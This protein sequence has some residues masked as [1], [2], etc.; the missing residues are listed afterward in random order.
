MLV[1]QP[2]GEVVDRL[3]ILALKCDRI[4]DPVRRAQAQTWHDALLARWAAADLPPLADLPELEPLRA[5]N[6]ELWDIE[7]ALRQC[8]RT[9][10]F[11][12]STASRPPEFT[13]RF[14][15]LA[16]RV[17]LANDERASLKAAIDRRLG[18]PLT[19]P[20][21]HAAATATAGIKPPEPS[22]S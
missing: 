18:S 15:A 5:V 10:Q 9:G 3:V 12:Q 13:D 2:Y 8:E 20:K 7:D 19:D 17:Y 4:T 1:P 6:A 14:V 11:S 21:Q 16:R 22:R